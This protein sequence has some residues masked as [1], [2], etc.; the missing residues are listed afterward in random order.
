MYVCICHGVTEKQIQKAAKNGVTS[1]T[2][3]QA[4]TGCGTG[5][6]SCVNMA[7]ETL[8]QAQNTP[9]FLN[10]RNQQ[11]NTQPLPSFA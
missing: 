1:L 8:M 9:D 4:E 7:I 6:G 3:L 10:V 5:C 2:Q 11:N